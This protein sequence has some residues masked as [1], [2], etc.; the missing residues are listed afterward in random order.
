[1][2]IETLDQIAAG[3]LPLDDH[4]A[5]RI[6][7]KC[8][9]A[10]KGKWEAP[11]L[12]RATKLAKKLSPT[13]EIDRK[14]RAAL[15][16]ARA[17][18]IHKMTSRKQADEERWKS[19]R[20]PQQAWQVMR[21][22]H[23]QMSRAVRQSGRLETF[24]IAYHTNLK[25]DET[26]YRLTVQRMPR[27]ANG[28][29]Y[30]LHLQGRDGQQNDFYTFK[31]YSPTLFSRLEL[32]YSNGEGFIRIRYA[33]QEKHAMVGVPIQSELS[34]LGS[35]RIVRGTHPPHIQSTPRLS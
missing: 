29:H 16:K 35:P 32:M 25:P 9:Q 26:D 30:R 19:L 4:F 27:L 3:A 31:E 10:V 20:A 23:H 7:G 17:T 1:M 15:I 6:M 34:W 21:N 22:L 28:M 14:T 18:S 13:G 5:D 24:D 8:W 12:D 2:N 33:T 11:S